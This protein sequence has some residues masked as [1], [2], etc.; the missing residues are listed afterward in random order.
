MGYTQ[1]EIKKEVEK[2]KMM[3]AG[4]ELDAIVAEKVMGLKVV[5]NKKGGWSIGPASWDDFAGEMI[6]SNPLPN[7]SG[8]IA[9]AWDVVEH[10]TKE[11]MFF[12]IQKRSFKYFEYYVFFG[13][14]PSRTAD[15]APLAICLAA[16]S[17]ISGEEV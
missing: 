15:T 14:A 3:E 9:V 16:L 8:D 7:Y 10:L 11:K 2:N 6:M 13:N 12:H 5:R 1:P 17:Y 4:R